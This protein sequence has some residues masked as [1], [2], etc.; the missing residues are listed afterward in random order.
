MRMKN[1]PGRSRRKVATNLS[2]RAAVAQQAKALGLNLSEV[3]EAALLDAIRRKR[4]QMWREENRSAIE[5]YNAKV[6]KEGLFSDD[7][8]KF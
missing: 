8:R 1:A 6:A 3:F 7:W 2:V 4:E 5:S